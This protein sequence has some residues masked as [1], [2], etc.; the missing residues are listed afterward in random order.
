MTHLK[1][2]KQTIGTLTLASG[3]LLSNQALANTQQLSYCSSP[4]GLKSQTL[5]F[6]LYHSQLPGQLATTEHSVRVSGSQF[7]IDSVSQAQGLLALFYSGELKQH[8]EGSVNKKTGFEPAYYSEARGKKPIK[9]TVVN[10][11]SDL[12]EFRKNGESAQWVKGTQDRLSMIY[13][14]SNLLVCNQK[15][16][17]PFEIVLPIMT[18]GRLESETF[19]SEGLE[20]VEIGQN[21]KKIQALRLSNSPKQGDDTI[22]IWF[23][24]NNQYLPVQIQVEES[25]GKSVTQRLLSHRFDKDITTQ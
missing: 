21:P 18:T 7:R 6:A 13:Q 25:D 16:K 11:E 5:T 23:D 2:L 15:I 3:V 20:E 22:R 19:K 9:E 8:S 14:I 1:H 24:P 10:S 12:V 4:D 17:D